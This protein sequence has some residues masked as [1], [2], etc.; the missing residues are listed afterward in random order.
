[1][2]HRPTELNQNA[3]I[4]PLILPGSRRMASPAEVSGAKLQLP[5]PPHLDHHPAGRQAIE[6][7]AAAH[8]ARFA[9]Q[10]GIAILQFPV[11]PVDL[12]SF[13]LD[14]T[15]MVGDDPE[16]LLL[17][18]AE[19]F[20]R[21]ADDD[22]QPGIVVE[23]GKAAG[24]RMSCSVNPKWRMRNAVVAATSGTWISI[25]FIRIVFLARLPR[26]NATRKSHENPP[27]AARDVP[28]LVAGSQRMT[29]GSELPCG[30]GRAY[31]I[32]PCLFRQAVL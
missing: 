21:V 26:R 12:G 28:F 4:S 11:N 32:R 8:L 15:E 3:K 20:D 6:Q 14:E 30:R 18:A 1:M 27:R 23:D 24:P 2:P 31:H 19:F 22:F 10:F 25:W 17:G 5:P 16:R 9:H 7:V 29:E 13:R